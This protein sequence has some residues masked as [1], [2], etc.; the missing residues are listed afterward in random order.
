MEEY[1]IKLLEPDKKNMSH[2]TVLSLRKQPGTELSTLLDHYKVSV[3]E[4]E[5]LEI[6]IKKNE[7]EINGTKK[8]IANMKDKITIRHSREVN[9]HGPKI[10]RIGRSGPSTIIGLKPKPS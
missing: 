5:K 3:T 1:E 6:E 4:K 8:H 7:Y 10:V 9:C 2:F